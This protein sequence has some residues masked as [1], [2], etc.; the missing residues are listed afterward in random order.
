MRLMAVRALAAT[1][2]LWSVALF[3]A[4]YALGRMPGSALSSGL[5]AAVYG[6]G[7]VL[8]HQR[9]ERSFHVWSVQLP[10]C[11]RCTGIY[12]GAAATAVAALADATAAAGR[13]SRPAAALACAA[14]PAVATLVYEWTLRVTPSDGIRA[15]SGVLLGAAVMAVLLNEVRHGR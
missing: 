6:I 8:C 13:I 12:V 14:A 1:A 4:A 10:V 15:A 2:I 11:A 5:A 3:A 9:P 7:S